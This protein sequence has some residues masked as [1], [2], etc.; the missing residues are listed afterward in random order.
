ML[1]ATLSEKTKV[2]M[3]AHTLGNPFD[4]HAVKDF[5]DKH[6]LLLVED[7]CDGLGSMH[8]FREK[9]G[10]SIQIM[11]SLISASALSAIGDGTV[12]VLLV[13]TT[14]AAIV[15]T[16][17]TVNYLGY[18]HK[19]VYSHF[20]YNL[21]A[22]DVQAAIGRAQLENFCLLW[23]KEG[24]T[25]TVYRL[26]CRDKRIKIILP[27]PCEHSAPRWFWFLITCREGTDRN[28]VVRYIELKGIQTRMLFAGNLSKHSCFDEIACFRSGIPLSW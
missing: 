21:K 1:E 28:A 19:Y 5:C 24:I 20:G 22:T 9:S 27:V 4:L 14:C 18:D 12:F 17:S 15:L 2:V 8:V 7:N 25:L 13:V 16:V 6:N 26:L 3:I 23:R 11:H 10:L